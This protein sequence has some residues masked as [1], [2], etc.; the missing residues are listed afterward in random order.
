MIRLIVG[1]S[2]NVGKGKLSIDEV[3]EA[4]R[5]KKKILPHALAAPAKGLF[6]RDILYDYL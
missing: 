1:M 5:Q 2:L 3:H 4:I 6:L